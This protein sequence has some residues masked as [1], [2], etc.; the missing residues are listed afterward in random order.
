VKKLTQELGMG[1]SGPRSFS[2]TR[3][4]SVTMKVMTPVDR[5][6][7]GLEARFIG[8]CTQW[9]F[10]THCGL[11]PHVGGS[12]G[13]SGRLRQASFRIRDSRSG[14]DL[15][16]LLLN[17]PLRVH[18]PTQVRVFLSAP[19]GVVR[20]CGSASA[21]THAPAIT[22]RKYR[23]QRPSRA[24][25]FYCLGSGLQW[26]GFN[27]LGIVSRIFASWNQLDGWLRQVEALRRVA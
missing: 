17:W 22:K 4:S 20:T 5:Y 2:N 1:W 11:M 26:C 10:E 12:N 7:T 3:P 16:W 14:G 23:D 27:K 25:R 18:I 24:V 8:V 21:A 13:S 15:S 6:S 9:C 19:P